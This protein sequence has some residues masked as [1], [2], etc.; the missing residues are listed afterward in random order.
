MLFQDI[1]LVKVKVTHQ[2]ILRFLV[3][4]VLGYHKDNKKRIAY[5]YFYR[6]CMY[7]YM[8]AYTIQFLA[9]LELF[10]S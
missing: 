3:L 10:E 6:Y 8:Y 1:I 7:I 9:F 4:N 5:A 2:M